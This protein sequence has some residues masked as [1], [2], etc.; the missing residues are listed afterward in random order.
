MKGCDIM[1]F[2]GCGVA[3][4]TPFKENGLVNFD[5]LKELI[6]F[7]IENKTD[8]LIICGTTGE[9]S[10]LSDLEK[11]EVIKF[12]IEVAN[13]KIPVIAG[14]GCNDTLKTIEMSKYAQSVN[15]SALLIVTPYY[16]K[17]SQDGLYQH[18]LKIASMVSIPIIL[19]NVP[20]RTGV[21]IDVDTVLRLSQIENIIAIKE[22]SSNISQIAKII[23]LVPNNFNV[24]SGNDDQTLPI[25][26]LGGIGVISVAANII[27]KQMHELCE[28][29][30]SNDIALARQI[31]YKYLDLMNSLFCDINP[32]PIKEAMNILNLN[33][34]NCRLPLSNMNDKNIEKLRLS[35]NK[36]NM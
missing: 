34:G 21:N 13:G 16:N 1:I 33:V 10:T 23:S 27:P 24:Y 36:L 8:A 28:K 3:L 32:I 2:K 29:Y 25:L 5:K 26:A 14:T 12:S 22:A 17:C 19:Y 31:Q 30:F 4:I 35:L 15:A 11:K 9:A 6:E 20:S 7:Q 18:Y